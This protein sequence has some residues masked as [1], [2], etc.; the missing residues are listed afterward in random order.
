MLS[1]Q[2]R[3][4]KPD[5]E[6]WRT[7]QARHSAYFVNANRITHTRFDAMELNQCAVLLPTLLEELS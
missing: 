3:G 1:C 4:K 5:Y 6:C 7:E 2:Q